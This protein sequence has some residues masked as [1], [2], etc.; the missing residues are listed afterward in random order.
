ML[1]I[2]KKKKKNNGFN[3]A[4]PP[5]ISLTC[6]RLV[7]WIGNHC[8]LIVSPHKCVIGAAAVAKCGAYLDK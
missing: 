3:I 4:S 1:T 8:H 7:S 6:C 2:K 5:I